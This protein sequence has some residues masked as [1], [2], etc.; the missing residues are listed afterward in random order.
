M[1]ANKLTETLCILQVSNP[2]QVSS[3]QVYHPF[4][5]SNIA[6][7]F[8]QILPSDHK[9]WC[10]ALETSN[11]WPIFGPIVSYTAPMGSIAPW[12]VTL[13]AALTTSD[14][15]HHWHHGAAHAAW[16]FSGKGIIPPPD[17]AA[18]LRRWKKLCVCFF[19]FINPMPIPLKHP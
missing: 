5:W 12:H 7:F 14:V 8:A 18:V 1:E 9:H 10:V 2:T 13:L 6:F 19:F 11:I 3:H 16:V 15:A 4:Q 17:C